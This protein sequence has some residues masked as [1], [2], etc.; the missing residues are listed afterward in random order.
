MKGSLY[1]DLSKLINYIEMLEVVS[2]PQFLV[3]KNSSKRRQQIAKAGKT[4][5]CRKGI[6]LDIQ[7]E[8]AA[9]L[10]ERTNCPANLE[11]QKIYTPGW[12]APRQEASRLPYPDIV[13]CYQTTLRKRFQV[14]PLVF[15]VF[16]QFWYV[17]S[18]TYPLQAYL[19]PIAHVYLPAYFNRDTV[20]IY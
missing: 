6:H 3:G 2:V 15:F 16:C 17:R 10:A 1:I 8:W 14:C 4:F 12:N 19:P 7:S 13:L 11:L 5:I 9:Q 20:C 18:L